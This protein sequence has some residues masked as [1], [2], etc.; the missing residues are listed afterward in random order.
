MLQIHRRTEPDFWKQYRKQHPSDRYD[1]LEN[2]E[3]GIQVRQA[4]RRSLVQSQHDL[5][6]YCCRK[7]SPNT[8]LNEHIRPR[9]LP[10]Y[11][12]YSMDFSNLIASCK[13]ATTCS[14]NKKN[15]YS[16]T[17]FVSPLQE[18]CMHHFR[19]LSNGEIEGTT[20]KGKYTVELLNLNSYELRKARQAKL[21]ACEAY[22]DPQMVKEIFLTPDSDGTLEAFADIILWFYNNGYFAVDCLL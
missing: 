5:C 9:G 4:L 10:E 12:K 17:L 11:T 18:D 20:E 8:A 19:F 1:D 16:E 6:A 14:G 21:K 15:K 13:T 7:I 3:E 22:G 2:S